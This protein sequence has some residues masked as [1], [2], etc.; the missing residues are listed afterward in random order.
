MD[1]IF[2]KVKVVEVRN[3]DSKESALKAF[4]TVEIGG[5]LIRGFRV[6][7]QKGQH[8]WVAPPQTSWKDKD[9]KTRFEPI[10]TLPEFLK[11]S[12]EAG[13]LLAWEGKIDAD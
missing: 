9:G 5:M 8:A 11:K 7:K 3:I 4:A 2:Q 13:V 10:I 6:I 12:I 1:T